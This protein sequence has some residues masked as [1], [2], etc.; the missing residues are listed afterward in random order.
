[1][2]EEVGF[3]FVEG[4]ETN[5]GKANSAGQDLVKGLANG[6]NNKNAQNSVYNAVTRLGQN[7]LAKARAIMQINSPS[8]AT[9]EMGVFL[10]QGLING[11]K[12]KQKEVDKTAW[13][14]KC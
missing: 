13:I 3:D 6:I 10:D 8:K 2:G 7:L 12:S 4:V 5:N 11:I 14:N 9:A 1:M